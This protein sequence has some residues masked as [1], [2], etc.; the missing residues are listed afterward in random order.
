SIVAECRI[1]YADAPTIFSSLN[2]FEV[3]QDARFSLYIRDSIV[4]RQ[5]FKKMQDQAVLIRS[6]NTTAVYDI[7][8]WK[9]KES[10]TER[11]K[12]V[13]YLMKR[14]QL[15]IIT[16]H[17]QGKLNL[18]TDSHYRLCRSGVTTLKDRTIQ[19]ICKTWN[20]MPQINLFATQYNKL[21]KKL[22]NC[23][24]QQPW[25][26]LAQRVQMQVRQSQIDK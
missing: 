6:D 17:I 12:Q 15:Q 26:T 3:V 16:I 20:Y 4:V 11:I 21:F 14:L 8:K 23:S 10:L 2:S 1:E 22:C 25:D 18:I 19:M 7:G 9:A 5:V 24:S 13:F